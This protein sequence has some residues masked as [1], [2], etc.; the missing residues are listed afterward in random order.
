[1]INIDNFKKSF[2]NF[3]ETKPFPICV[4][5]DFL[6]IEYAKT[7][8]KEFPDYHSELYNGNYNN[9]I[10]I[11]KTCNRWDNFLPATYNLIHYLNSDSFIDLI[12]QSTGIKTLYA[13]F[14]LHG[15]G[16]H[17]HCRGGKLN[18]HLDYTVHPKL[19]LL[20]KYNLLIYLTSD[21]QSQWKGEFGIWEGGK[22]NHHL[23]LHDKISPL[24][25]RA[26]FFDTTQ[27]SWHGIVETV[28]CPDYVTRKSIAVY[29]LI[30]RDFDLDLRKRA[31]FA[32]TDNQKNDPLILDLIK[33]RS[34]ISNS[35][36]NDWD[37]Q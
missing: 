23:K 34:Q 30:D 7:I 36:V 16:Q 33:R 24:F 1:M 22:D 25:N 14:G 18:P 21:W 26:I 4:I 8:E 11:K 12:K 20:R 19:G 37:R 32:P 28:N 9:S 5:D 6:E 35:N 3:A 10:E 13:D 17:I 29:Y 27:D 2:K 15:G 31:L